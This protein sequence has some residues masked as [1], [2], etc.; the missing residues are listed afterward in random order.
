M[1]KSKVTSKYQVT[2]P[3]EVREKVGVEAGEMVL[4]EAVSKSEIRLR[5]FP[6]VPEPMKILVGSRG[7]PKP[8]PMSELDEMAESR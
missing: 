8:L 3:R 2:I 4:V 1:P 6:G 5:R 7:S